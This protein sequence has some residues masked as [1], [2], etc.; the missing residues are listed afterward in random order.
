MQRLSTDPS[1]VVL[2]SAPK[3]FVG[4]SYPY[5]SQ[6]P[7]LLKVSFLMRSL[8]SWSMTKND[9]DFSL[10]FSSNSGLPISERKSKQGR[11]V[12]GEGEKGMHVRTHEGDRRHYWWWIRKTQHPEIKPPNSPS[13]FSSAFYLC[14][15]CHILFSYLVAVMCVWCILQKFQLYIL[16]WFLSAFM[17]NFLKAL[18]KS[19]HMSNMLLLCRY[20][21][22][23]VC[24]LPCSEAHF[25]ALWWQQ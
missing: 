17:D 2:C 8:S 6:A 20:Y 12:K 5:S 24:C 16:L 13:P 19:S 23:P 15:V 3:Y 4:D 14:T 18:L 9:M 25:I 21:R 7:P 1:D 11:E 22:Y 10:S